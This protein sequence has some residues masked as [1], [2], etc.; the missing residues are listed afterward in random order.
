M[1]RD[2]R[3][4][5]EGLKLDEALLASMTPRLAQKSLQNPFQTWIPL[6]RAGRTPHGRGGGRGNGLPTQRMV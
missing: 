6:T 3:D 1:S 4:V 2:T 5:D